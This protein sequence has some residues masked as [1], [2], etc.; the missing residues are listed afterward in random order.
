MR[1]QSLALPFVLILILSFSAYGQRSNVEEMKQFKNLS[2][3]IWEEV[4][5][6]SCTNDW[7]QQW[8]LDGKKATISHSNKG[9]DFKAGPIRK[10]NASHAVLWS[11]QSYK[12]DIRLD[13][14]Y[15]K[16]DDIEEAV[17]ILYIQATGSGDDGYDKDIFL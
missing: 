7:K 8:T 2:N 1:L 15:T 9:M 4:F 6:D 11:K 16:I 14:E 13:Y 17:T 10:E 12:G 5:Y 3:L